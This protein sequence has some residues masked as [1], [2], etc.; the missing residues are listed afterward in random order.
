MIALPT[1]RKG[2]LQLLCLE[3]T[4]TTGPLEHSR[5]SMQCSASTSLPL[6]P[7][8]PGQSPAH[9][10]HQQPGAAD[11]SWPHTHAQPPQAH[12]TLRPSI[13]THML[14]LLSKTA[15]LL[16]EM[17]PV[18][19]NKRRHKGACASHACHAELSLLVESSLVESIRNDPNTPC[20]PKPLQLC[21][22]ACKAEAPVVTAT[23]HQLAHA[24]NSTPT[25]LLVWT[26]TAA[27]S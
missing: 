18:Q 14:Q 17:A 21:P 16:T 1:N 2:V 6:S 23:Y 25:H 9:R 24:P 27:P 3:A 10:M 15:L 7:R 20:R 5:P 13:Q 12:P 19:E 26:H 11:V 8:W 22:R 4:A